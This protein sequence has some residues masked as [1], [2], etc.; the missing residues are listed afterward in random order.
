[1]GFTL[2][3]VVREFMTDDLGLPAI[4]SRYPRFLSLAISGLRDLYNDNIGDYDKE[5]L[6]PVEDS[7]VVFLPNDYID[8][9]AIGFTNGNEFIGL[10]LNGNITDVSKDDCGDRIVQE[11]VTTDNF[12]QIQ[13]AP[14]ND[15]GEYLGTDYG[16]GGGKSSVGEYKI[17]KDKGYIALSGFSGTDI[18]L[19][20]KADIQFQNGESNIHTYNVEAVKA[21]IWLKYVSKSRSHNLGQIQ[22]AQTDYKKKKN[23]AL[24]RRSRFSVREFLS[25]YKSGFKGSPRI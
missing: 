7:G 18:V 25:A 9:Y 15:K 1:M 10:G 2:D 6:L 19:R 3:S 13:H 8:Y 20:Y 4:D 14:F 16:V 24:M 5:V 17:Y 12:Y 11:V 22:L 23:Q 21:W